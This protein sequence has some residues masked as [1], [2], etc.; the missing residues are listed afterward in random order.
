[1]GLLSPPRRPVPRAPRLPGARAFRKND[2]RNPLAPCGYLEGEPLLVDTAYGRYA[3]RRIACHRSREIVDFLTF[4]REGGHS[5]SDH[6][7]GLRRIDHG[8]LRRMANESASPS[9]AKT[10]INGLSL[11]APSAA[12]ANAAYARIASTLFRQAL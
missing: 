6:R 11:H 3:V 2:T 4:S 8:I 12:Q 1:M 7:I 5:H 9:Y 10:S